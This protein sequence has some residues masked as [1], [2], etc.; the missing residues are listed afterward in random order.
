MSDY[1]DLTVTQR[2]AHLVF[3]YEQEVQNGG[4]MQYFENQGIGRI[5][6]VI[7]ALKRLGA[8]CQAEVL[9]LAATQYGYKPRSRIKSVK[10]YVEKALKAE[11]DQ[12]DQAFHECQPSLEATLQA[13]LA[14]NQSEF[15]VVTD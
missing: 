12:L 9:F 7:G 13:F 2:F 5:K 6:E 3:W 11:F 8:H 15:V 1:T 14:K 4:H 10:E